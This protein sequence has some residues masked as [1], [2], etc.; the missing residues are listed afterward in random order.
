MKKLLIIPLLFLLA[1][2]K[3]ET[4]Q[5]AQSPQQNQNVPPPPVTPSVFPGSYIR[6]SV[7]C[8]NPS[9]TGWALQTL[10]LSQA[11][12]SI[13]IPANALNVGI[14]LPV[15]AYVSGTTA[16]MNSMYIDVHHTFSGGTMSIS[17]NTLT[18]HYGFKLF[19]DGGDLL[20]D[21]V[22]D[23]VYTK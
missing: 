6:Q 20:S 13:T 19:Y 17:G 11:G 14:D 1:C 2:S 7:I 21:N 23:L 10:T 22:Y 12:S 18:M 16:T 15:T 4:P 9:Y 5:P 8:S 3:K